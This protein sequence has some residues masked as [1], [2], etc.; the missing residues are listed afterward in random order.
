MIIFYMRVPW[1]HLKTNNHMKNLLKISALLLIF[2]LGYVQTG[3]SFNNTATDSAQVSN[4][5]KQVTLSVKGMTCGGCESKVCKALD[6]KDGVVSRT[7]SHKDG[8]AVVEYD[9]TKI[10]EKEI[11]KAISG[12]G[13]KASIKQEEKSN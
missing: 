4:E 12:T 8:N 6:K 11:V 9:P 1:D 2:S 3:S 7:V 5:T 10:S 13:F